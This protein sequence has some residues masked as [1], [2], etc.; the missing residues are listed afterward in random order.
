MRSMPGCGSGIG[1]GS[2][3]LL[4]PSGR[5]C[6]GMFHRGQG[7]VHGRALRNGFWVA[8][9]ASPDGASTPLSATDL[10]MVKEAAV[11]ADGSAGLTI[12]HPNHACI[13]TGADGEVIARA[14]QYAQGTTS[15]EVQAVAAAGAGARGGTAYLNLESGDCHGDDSAVNSLIEAGVTRVVVGLKH[16]L[17]HLHGRAIEVLAGAGVEVQVLGFNGSASGPESDLAAAEEEAVLACLRVNEPLLHRTVTTRPFSVLKYAMTMDGKIAT[18][19]GHSAWVS[20]PAARQQVFEVRSRSDAVIVGGNTVR[21]DNPR[22]TT[23]REGGHIPVRVV[24]SRTLDLPEDA[25]LWDTSSAPTI[26]MTQR[27]ARAAFQEHL[28]SKGV[29]VIEFA[30]LSPSAVIE[31]CYSRGF[32]QCLWEC[33]GMLSAP[34]ISGGV[35]HKT[36]AFIAP[37]IIG[38]ARAPTPVGEL[39]FVEMTQA[40][41]ITDTTFEVVGSDMMMTGYLPASGGLRALAEAAEEA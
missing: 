30:F 19:Q 14:F 1:A 32:M 8:A 16:P 10:E 41:D 23:R 18:A 15:A 35:I 6:S 31:Y 4:S 27:G 28:R 20:C 37:K 3:V 24:M 36:M 13:I 29:E 17:K 39:G 11:A 22:L 38:G 40:V 7:T 12:P 25:N 5:G 21:R 2:V 34:A 9:S 33:G 26:V